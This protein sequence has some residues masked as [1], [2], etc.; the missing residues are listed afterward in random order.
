MNFDDSRKYEMMTLDCRDNMVHTFVL[1][2]YININE[3]TDKVEEF[4]NQ[5]NDI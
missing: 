1:K 5:L 2:Y 3:D 4:I